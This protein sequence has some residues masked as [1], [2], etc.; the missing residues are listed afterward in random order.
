MGCPDLTI[1]QLARHVG[2]ITSSSCSVMAVRSGDHLR[3]RHEGYLRS[4]LLVA[5]LR[6]NHEVNNS[7]AMSFCMPVSGRDPGPRCNVVTSSRVALVPTGLHAWEL[8]CVV[9]TL[10]LSHRSWKNPSTHEVQVSTSVALSAP[11]RAVKQKKNNR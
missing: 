6:S 2:V 3:R 4:D 10:C 7:I 5:T 8:I 9:R 11:F 1:W